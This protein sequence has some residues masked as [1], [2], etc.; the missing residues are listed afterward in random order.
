MQCHEF[1][2]LT[3]LNHC[4]FFKFYCTLP[5]NSSVGGNLLI[6][7]NATVNGT[8]EAMDGI[9][10]PLV[11]ISGLLK[12]NNALIQGNLTTTSAQIDDTLRVGERA[13]LGSSSD[14][15]HSN[16]GSLIVN[17]TS[18][19][20]TSK[21]FG[22]NATF[23]GTVELVHANVTNYLTAEEIIASKITS[24]DSISIPRGNLEVTKGSVQCMDLISNG[25]LIANGD[26]LAH[27]QI[28]TPKL[29]VT[30]S[31][32]TTM[33]TGEYAMFEMAYLNNVT[34]GN[35][36]IEDS[37]NSNIVHAN[38]IEVKDGIKARS[39]IGK[40]MYTED[41]A[42]SGI[43]T[44]QSLFIKGDTKMN[45]IV[46]ISDQTTIQAK[47][48][49]KQLEVEDSFESTT[50]TFRGSVTAAGMEVRKLNVNGDMMV[51]GIDVVDV[52]NQ[53]SELTKRVEKLEAMLQNT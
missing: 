37:V 43:I 33:M 28:F 44:S 21:L 19:S 42:A 31:I 30:E 9:Y 36:T 20:I 41:I 5:C 8:I 4:V 11:T 3:L 39:Y 51:N 38:D 24:L 50:A 15:D 13:I 18:V 26:I 7:A 23:H 29:H 2:I 16:I 40:R 22:N 46:D 12:S 48:I 53:L 45:G 17:T 27:E 47:L 1:S 35:M 34:A 52:L 25:T 32:N 49:A 6:A 10:A 14:S